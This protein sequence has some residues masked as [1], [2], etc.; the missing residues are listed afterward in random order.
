MHKLFPDIFKHLCL[1]CAIFFLLSLTT[2][3]SG[4]TPRLTVVIVVDG[5]H[6]QDM[7]AL[8]PYWQQGGL[9]LLSEEAF[10]TE[11]PLPN[12]VYGGAETAATLFCGTTPDEH[13]IT[14]DTFFQRS[15]RRLHSIFEDNS[16]QGIG[17]DLH[18]SPHNILSMSMSDK[19]RLRHGSKANIYAIGL[20][21]NT[22]LC[23]A[24][25]SANACCWFN[26]DTR[27]WVTTTYYDEGLPAAA[28]RQ[29]TSGR[30]EQLAA[31]EWTPRLDIAQ[32]MHPTPE[33][34]KRSFSYTGFA[35]GRSAVI[36]TLV[37]ELALDLQKDRHLG[38][39]AVPDLLLL[40]MTVQ[41][42]AAQ[43]DHIQCAEQEDMYL[44]LNQDIG[45]LLEQLGKRIGKQHMQ[46][47]LTGLP[48]LGTSPEP[49]NGAGLP[50]RRFNVDRAV[51]LTGT[52]LM[53][54][55]GHERW[56]DG[57][58]GQSIFLNRTLIEQ[59]KLSVSAL[60]RQVSDFLLDF[61]GVQG[62]CPSGELRLI[63]T[64]GEA[65]RLRMSLN[66]HSAGDVVFW[67][68]ENWVSMT[69]EN[70]VPDKV[71]DRAPAVPLYLWSGKLRQFP[72][73]HQISALDL[74]NLLFE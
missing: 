28:D 42:P 47:L 15:D 39:D 65:E 49:L 26:S 46:V 41:S 18:V 25:H 63:Q 3:V 8:R 35:G 57:G 7:D 23:A 55:Y 64:G 56:V 10:Q 38:E 21:A 37:C 54:L 1:V 61:E 69:R 66:K 68:E 24:G 29:N 71:T 20:D 58:F 34:K 6:Q 19:F 53:A 5:M 43:S 11:L 72:D 51:A 22:T 13:G 9:R 14:F 30:I 4:E 36:N 59:K 16:Q 31:R 62:A 50:A 67:L 44:S 70:E 40:Q 52:Y 32:Y 17:T 60:Q 33:E 73:K 48:R 74:Y 2:Y 45:F 12:L 27:R